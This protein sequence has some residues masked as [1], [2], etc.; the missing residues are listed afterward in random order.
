[1]RIKISQNHKAQGFPEPGESLA[2]V[3]GATQKNAKP[4]IHFNAGQGGVTYAVAREYPPM[5][6][7]MTPE[8]KRDCEVIRGQAFPET[9][10]EFD[11]VELVGLPCIVVITIK[12]GAGGKTKAVVDAIKPATKE[13]AK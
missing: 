3:S 10:E 5:L 11:L 6:E 8:L 4:S 13:T 12:K 7:S 9:Q 1:M 2:N